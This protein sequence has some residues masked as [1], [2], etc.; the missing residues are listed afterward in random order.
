MYIHGIYQMENVYLHLILFVSL[1]R[2]TANTMRRN[3]IGTFLIAL[4]TMLATAQDLESLQT[5][6]DALHDKQQ[7]EPSRVYIAEFDDLS[8]RSGDTYYQAYADY[9]KGCL[10]LTENNYPDAS[11]RLHEAKKKATTLTMNP[12]SQKLRVRIALALGVCYLQA[13]MLPEAYQCLQEG[14][15]LNKE[16][17]DS[18]LQFKLDHDILSIYS[19]F[20]L[21]DEILALGN[22]ILSNPAYE[23]YNKHITYSIIAQCHYNKRNTDSAKLYLDTAITYAESAIDSAMVYYFRGNIY[24]ENKNYDEAIEEFNKG[25]TVV[26]DEPNQEM[27]AQLL[28]EKASAMAFLGHLDSAFVLI[29][30]ALDKTDS[31]ELLYLKEKGLKY[32]QQWL[33]QIGKYEEYAEVSA[34]HEAIS[35]SL[36]ALMDLNKLQRLDLNNRLELV[37]TQMEQERLM[38]DLRQQ[39]HRLILYLVIV[40]MLFVIVT[41]VL[42]L[43]R[44]KLLLDLRNREL[45][46]KSLGYN[47][48]DFDYY[49]TQTHP[50]FYKNLNH[51]HPDLTPYETHLCAY[52]RLNLTTKD[53]ANICGIE[54]SSVRMARY[55]LRKSLGI[56][57]SNTDL[58]KYLSKF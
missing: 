44:N 51:E 27:S 43:N 7:Y 52:I 19:F 31:E 22:E 30:K 4:A 50:D 20:D 37:K 15:E 58:T 36:E 54:P 18:Y 13:R 56:T 11:T 46:A 55:R 16:L 9:Y 33:Y 29:D 48:K 12:N 45:T 2:K 21:N 38:N 42:L 1:L 40:A 23:Q 25:L 24:K 17:G 6:I 26:E 41:I 34:Q 8:S 10:L 28:T 5:V 39:R 57:D 53:I 49:F 14:I 47:P 35:D 32:K 3:I